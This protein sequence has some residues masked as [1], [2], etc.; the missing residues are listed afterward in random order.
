MAN[1][2]AFLLP[3][4]AVE[5]HATLLLASLSLSGFDH[6]FRIKKAKTNTQFHQIVNISY[7]QKSREEREE[8]AHRRRFFLERGK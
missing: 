8:C 3:R 4:M 6:Y 5:I 2:A 7:F 1:C